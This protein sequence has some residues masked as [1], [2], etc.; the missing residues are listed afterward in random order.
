MEYT[1]RKGK[2]LFDPASLRTKGGRQ[3]L[4]YDIMPRLLPKPSE[5][6]RRSRPGP[7]TLTGQSVKHAREDRDRGRIRRRINVE[8]KREMARD[9]TSVQPKPRKKKKRRETTKF[10]RPAQEGR[11]GPEAGH[12]RRRSRR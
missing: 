4:I 3:T 7:G 11:R 10:F 12:G 5:D 8:N 1:S 9:E 2:K 6:R